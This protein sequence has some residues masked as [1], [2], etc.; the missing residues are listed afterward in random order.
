MGGPVSPYYDFIKVDSTRRGKISDKLFTNRM[1]LKNTYLL[2]LQLTTISDVHV[3]T[4]VKELEENGVPEIIMLQYVNNTEGKPAIPGSSFK[5]VVSTNYLALT[6]SIELT[7][8][9]FGSDRPAAIS[10]VFFEDT[11]PP[12][13][14]ELKLVKVQREWKPRIL[15]PKS[16]KVYTAKAPPTVHYGSMQCIP[17]GTLL[18]TTIRGVGIKDFELGGLLMSLGLNLKNNEVTTEAIKLGYG[19]PQG[20]GQLK[21]IPENSKIQSV[22]FK[23]LTKDIKSQGTLKES[24]TVNGY[25][26]AFMNEINKRDPKRNLD[27]TFQK[28]FKGI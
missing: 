20:F 11:V 5:G 18:A 9:L 19:K 3:S 22:E 1:E 13:S 12:K 27:Q 2:E 7:S 10:K 16:V 23:G 15:V 17:K 21:L 28:I 8:E 4:G 24:N 6:G 26:K 25:I 14:I